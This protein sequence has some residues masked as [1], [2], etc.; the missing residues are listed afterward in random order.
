MMAEDRSIRR[1]LVALDASP[2]SIAAL[3]GA[4]RLASVLGAELLGLYVEDEMLLRGVELQITRAVGSFSGTVRQVERAELE[5]HLRTQAAN[6]RRALE[7]VAAQAHL[8]YSFRI[9]R[10]TVA[11]E[12]LAAAAQVDLISL[13]RSGWSPIQ[14]HRIGTTTETILSRTDAPVFLLR[15]GLRMGQSVVTVYDGSTPARNAL[16]LAVQIAHHESTPLV[17]VFPTLGTHADSLKVEVE[18]DL[19]ALGVNRPIRYRS[20]DHTNAALLGALAR[21]EDAAIVLLPMKDISERG[22]KQL[23]AGLDCPVLVVR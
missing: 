6:A 1:I 13:G 8:R 17:L 23:L 14:S 4:A 11:T 16:K 20:V 15:R 12:L 10:G 19:D 7:S 5:R 22:F 18:N 2:S 3:E 21:H 9:T